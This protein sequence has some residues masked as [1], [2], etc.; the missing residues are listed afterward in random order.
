[1]STIDFNA[2]LG[3]SFGTWEKGADEAMLGS[4]SSA[5]VACGFHAGD[6]LTMATTVALVKQSEIALGAHP[7]Y[8][9]LLGF[10]RRRLDASGKE[11]AAYVTY[12]V[13]ALLG[14]AHQH[15]LALHHVKPHG[16]LYA[17][18]LSEEPVARAVASAVAG[19]VPGTFLYTLPDSEMWKAAVEHDL[20]PVAEFFADRPLRPDGSYEFFRWRDNF[21]LDP[22]AVAERTLRAIGEGKVRALDGSDLE[23]TVDSVCLHSD[24]P[25]AEQLG[26]HLRIALE[27][28]GWKVA[29]P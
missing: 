19:L 3:E 16:A 10:G 12:Q 2:D 17:A 29:A 15:Q 25:G 11:V 1:M 27:A 6:P 24:T 22:D 7:G 26:P 20:Q 5:N 21:D 18:A 23:V 14:F 8:P 28:A 13:G 4:V 9:D